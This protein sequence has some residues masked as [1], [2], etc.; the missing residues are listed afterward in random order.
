VRCWVEGDVVPIVTEAQRVAR[1]KELLAELNKVPP[2]KHEV[3]RVP[4]PGNEPRHCQVIKIHV[5]EVVL[6]PRSHRVRAQLEDDPEWAE[7]KDDPF[8]ESAQVVIQRQVREARTREEFATLKDSLSNEGQS[9]PGVVTSKGVLINA[10]TRAVA[11]RELDDPN[12]RYIRVAVLPETM[13][14]DELAL[15]E[16][17]LQMQKELKVDYSLTNELLFIE[18]LSVER[19]MPPAQIGKELRIGETVKKGEGE[20]SLRLKFLDLL[21]TMQKLPREGLRL[22]FFDAL[23]Y[24]QLRDLYRAYGAVVDNDPVRATSVLEAFL[25]SVSVGVTPVHQLR[26]IDPDFIPEYMLPQLEE[27]E[28]IGAHAAKLAA[29]PMQTIAK[30]TGVGALLTG[31]GDS[32]V[33]EVNVRGLIDIVTQR[34]HKVPIPGTNFV[35][36]RDDVK[37]A[38]KTAIINGVTEKKRDD[39]ASDRLQAPIDRV[40]LAA[41]QV[42]KCTEACVGVIG[43]TEF[44]D[45]RRKTLEVAYKRLQKNF[46]VLE[47]ELV[48]SSVIKG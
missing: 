47:A 42:D 19:S 17:R 41:K 11:F 37:D 23:G 25:L 12:K 4:G 5:D 13:Q 30:P 43:T 15:L 6:N 46:R 44:G 7:N 21:R 9:D 1:I 16:L 32:D 27:D 26:R 18:E 35:L 22:T 39:S 20:V 45:S 34:D 24:E 3:I 10:N 8:S 29:L 40:R 33:T 14:E 38:V 36:E 2:E 28:M 48:K 31:D